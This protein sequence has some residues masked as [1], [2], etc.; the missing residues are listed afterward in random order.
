MEVLTLVMVM[1]IILTIMILSTRVQTIMDLTGQDTGHL[2]RI[3]LTGE[4][5]IIIIP[6]LIMEI[7]TG[8]MMFM[9]GSAGQVRQTEML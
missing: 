5:L 3:T 4:I 1:V 9:L 6:A 7:R 8:R 2:I